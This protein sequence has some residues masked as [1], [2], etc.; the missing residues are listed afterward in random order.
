MKS[1][2]KII[3]DPSI[4]QSLV[5]DSLRVL[6]EEVARR[7]GLGGMAIKGPY[8]VVKN[9]QGGRILEKAVRALVPEFVD[10]LD[11]YYIRFQKDGAGKTWE[12]YLRPH[13]LTLSDELLSVTDRKI[14]E[15]DNRVVRGAYDKLRPKARK[16]V[17]ASMPALTR[18]MERYI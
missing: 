12:E 15:T 4:M 16:E 14:R 9:V 1:L 18:M 3:E 10:K 7:S 17:A 13:H 6:D 5:A 11:P 2:K 8:R